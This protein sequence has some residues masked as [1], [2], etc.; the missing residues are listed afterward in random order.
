VENLL[1]WW[2]IATDE[3]GM[4]KLQGNLLFNYDVDPMVIAKQLQLKINGVPTEFKLSDQGIGKELK[5]QTTSISAQS[6]AS[7]KLEYTISAGA[8]CVQ[9]GQGIPAAIPEHWM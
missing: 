2:S 8:T 5:F 6:I 1:T 3:P 7:S 9:C 4:V